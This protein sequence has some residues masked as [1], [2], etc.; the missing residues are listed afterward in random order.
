VGGSS[1]TTSASAKRAPAKKA[2][3]K[4]A[5]KKAT[6]KSTSVEPQPMP[7]PASQAMLRANA[8]SSRLDTFTTSK[9]E[10]TGVGGDCRWRHARAV[11]LTD[12]NRAAI[13][14]IIAEAVMD[15][16][17]GNSNAKTMWSTAIVNGEKLTGKD[18][19]VVEQFIDDVF[20]LPGQKMRSADHLIGHVGEWLWYLHLTEVAEEHRTILHL[21][22]PKFGVTDQGA[23][24]LALYAATGD[25]TT[26]Y[27]LWEMKKLTGAGPVSDT[28]GGAYRQLKRKGGKYLAKLTKGYSSQPGAVGQIGSELVE[29]W[30]NSNERAGVGV[31]VA[32]D[33]MPP[34]DTCFTTMGTYFPGLDKAGQLE[35]LLFTVEDLWQLAVTV[36]EYLW[37]AL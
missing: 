16:R 29:L 31:S 22:S 11:G 33:R 4:T 17:C 9:L 26:S 23:D 32:T 35:G 2:A 14:W 18:A 10:D 7:C 27:C 28:T 8:V 6:K 36:R 12:E 13:A 24:G 15:S 34:E 20:G 3:A 37:T 19:E 5:S 21:E 30:V 1:A 25:G